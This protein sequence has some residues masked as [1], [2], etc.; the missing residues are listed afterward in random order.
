MSGWTL[1][2]VRGKPASE[3]ELTDQDWDNDRGEATHDIA[4]T[5][6]EDD[7]VRAWENY[8]YDHV[9][10]LLMCSR[11]NWEFA[12]EFLSDYGKMVDDAVVLGWNDTTDSGCARYYE[13]PDL[14]QWSNQYEETEPHKGERACAVMY[15]QHGI[16]A[17]NPF[18]NNTGG[19]WREKHL[20]SG[21][22]Q[23]SAITH[24]NP[25]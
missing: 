13:R 7:R 12:E 4:A 14:G 19:H 9:Y 3:Y 24:T 21:T 5:F 2:T 11:Y 18:H 23:E 20:D 17:Q 16:Y 22:V 1:I 15:A 25:K 8:S 10:A 6:E